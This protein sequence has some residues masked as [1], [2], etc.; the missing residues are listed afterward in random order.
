ML[1]PA[2]MHYVTVRTIEVH[3]GSPACTSLRASAVAHAHHRHRPFTSGG[4]HMMQ[5]S[6]VHRVWVYSH[7]LHV[8]VRVIVTST[9]TV[10]GASELAFIWFIS[11]WSFDDLQGEHE[12]VGSPGGVGP[13]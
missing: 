4:G 7:N 11:P 3:W 2:H 8:V 10:P 6:R 12:L 1:H 13:R 5:P 9:S